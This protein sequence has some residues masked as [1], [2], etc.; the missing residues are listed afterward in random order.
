MSS[1][2]D[3]VDAFKFLSAKQNI[4]EDAHGNV[5]CLD[6]DVMYIKPSGIEY[7][8]ITI[9]DIATIV[10][11]GDSYVKIGLKKESVDTNHHIQIYCNN[12]DI[13]SICHTHSP[14]ATACAIAC[15]AV[16]VVCTE[17]ADYFGHDI[18]V[19]PYKDLNDWGKYIL[20]N[21]NEKAILLGNHGVL[22]FGN[23]PLEAAKRAVALEA[24]C[25]KFVLAS[26]ASQKIKA[27]PQIEV[28]KWY[29]R[30]V[31]SYGQKS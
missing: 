2:K 12:I 31:N 25:K 14:Y 11:N 10:R 29:E 26:Q 18:R 22:T 3:L 16:P 17:H 20:L 24:V 15:Y 28:N 21:E 5:S 30:Y 8:D 7:D 6:N 27:L 13:K 4:V 23:T 1:K 9:D 19:L